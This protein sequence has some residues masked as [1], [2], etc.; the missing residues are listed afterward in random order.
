M[1]ELS[2][3][4]G[5]TDSIRSNYKIMKDLDSVTKMSPNYRRTMIKKFIDE[6]KKNEVTREILSGW[7]LQLNNDIDQFRGRVFDPE[8]I[9]FGNNVTFQPKRDR[10]GDWGAAAVRNHVLRTVSISKMFVLIEN[11]KTSK[12]NENYFIKNIVV[13]RSCISAKSKRVAYFLYS[14]R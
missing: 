13:F 8:V 10:P 14:K 7:G 5:L 12:S 9:Q 2:Y 11:C 3:A 6:I 1:P 4:A